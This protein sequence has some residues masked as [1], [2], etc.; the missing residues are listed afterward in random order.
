VYSESNNPKIEMYK[1]LSAPTYSISEV[2]RLAKISRGRISR[3][4]RGYK[5]EGGKQDPVIERSIP[6]E[7]TYA[8]FLDLI[9][10]LFVKK[11]IERGF[12]LQQIRKALD[13][14]RVHLGTPHFARNKF[15]TSNQNIILELPKSSKNMVSLL[16]DGQ[17][18]MGDLVEQVFDK[19]DFEDVTEF[20]FASRWYPEGRQG[21]IIIDPQI[22]FGRPTIKGKG[23]ATE[24]IFDLYLG[25]DKKIEPV[26]KWFQLSRPEVQAAIRFETG[27]VA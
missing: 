22:S 19:L 6:P 27:L 11:F 5:Y 26:R 24:N 25:E 3:W 8:S 14:A 7:S 12:S 13:E 1:T 21:F 20:G 17:R 16:S 15:F 2:Q 4:L 18:V 9:D 10:L 23:I